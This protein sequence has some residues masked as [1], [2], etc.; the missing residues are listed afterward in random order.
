MGTIS[1][2]LQT[3][4][5]I[6]NVIKDPLHDATYWGDKIADKALDIYLS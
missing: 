3:S 5:D 1:F 6:L 4:D 2:L